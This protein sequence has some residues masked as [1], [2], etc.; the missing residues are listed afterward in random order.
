PV[1]PTRRDRAFSELMKLFEER[2]FAKRMKRM[3]NGISKP[4]DSGEY[5]LAVLELQRMLGPFLA[6]VL[7]I[8]AIAFLMTIETTH[9]VQEKVVAVTVIE[10]TEEPK[11][12]DE[13]PPP[14]ME[15]FEFEMI[16]TAFDGPT[17]NFNPQQVT[18][19]AHSEPVSPKPAAIN[20]V[21]IIKSPIVM[22]GIVG[23]RSP[24]HRGQALAEFKGSS[25]GEAT[26]MRALR[27]LKAQQKEDGSW[28]G[29][30]TAMTGMALLCYLAHGETP[31]AEC[32]EFGPTVERGLR[33]L[34]DNQNDN[35]LFRSKDGNNYAHPIA[36]YALCE[37][38]TLT[39]VP[40]VK[41]AAEKALRHII[42]GQHPNGGWD[43]NMRQTQRD[44][45]SYM[46]WCAQALKAGMMGEDLDAPGLEKACHN[47][48]NGF[49]LNAHPSGGFGYTSPGRGG[50]SGVGVLCM[51]LLGAAKEP[52]VE[53]TLAYLDNFNFSFEN[54]RGLGGNPVY[55]WYYIT[56]AKFHAGG[57]RWTSWNKQ[58]QPELIKR[59]V[60][61]KDG[62][63]D[64]DGNLRDIGYW[65]SPSESES[66]AGAGPALP[67]IHWEGGKDSREITATTTIGHRVQDTCLCALQLMVYYRYLPT[68]KTPVAVEE[69]V[70]VVDDDEVKINII[71]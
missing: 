34:C 60:V 25:A 71:R 22:R 43:Y 20:T 17:E 44:D 29:Q 58:F 59:Q 35:G 8:V 27:W 21:A 9:E 38:Y 19:F 65:D 67:S 54:W 48:V 50:L 16:D 69:D 41:I 4:K 51:Q 6:I 3:I 66:G 30:A 2:T 12:E 28:P 46:G 10:A 49:K 47:A 31:R 70:P 5:K 63:T 11:I 62:I 18:T 55:Y 37:A 52:E 61:I 53:S 40:M 68:F 45:T 26:V 33:Y 1:S 23:S 24:G 36:T 64:P 57:D 7:P 15:E 39:K 56:Q 14:P 32:V 13:P 42:E